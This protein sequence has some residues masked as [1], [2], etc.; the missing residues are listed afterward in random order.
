MV[1][2]YVLALTL[3]KMKKNERKI[4]YSNSKHSNPELSLSLWPKQMLRCKPIQDVKK[5]QRQSP[6]NQWSVNK[7]HKA[8]VNQPP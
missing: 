8:L 6:E 3:D 2:V 7:K 1:P 5:P 4:Y